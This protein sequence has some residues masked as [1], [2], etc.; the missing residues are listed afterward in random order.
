VVV[1]TSS[2]EEKVLI[3]SYNL[4]VNSYISK[5]VDFDQFVETIRYIGYYWLVLNKG[6][7]KVL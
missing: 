7:G 4:G 5:P 3:E 6:V 2:K 1:L